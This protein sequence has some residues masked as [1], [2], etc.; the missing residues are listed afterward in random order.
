MIKNP[1]ALFHIMLMLTRWLLDDAWNHIDSIF[2][3]AF[4]RTS[5][6]N[7]KPIHDDNI[8]QRIYLNPRHI[9]HVQEKALNYSFDNNDQKNLDDI[10]LAY[11]TE[12]E[13]IMTQLEK[14]NVLKINNTNNQ[15]KLS[16]SRTYNVDD[17]GNP[18]KCQGKGRP[19]T[20]RLKA[21]NEQKNKVSTTQKS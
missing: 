20:K 3:E 18:L 21:Y 13:T 17:I 11:I 4:I 6:K 12:K 5:S 14:G 9:N 15:L 1:N 2:N 7:L 19:A 16:D 8:D 10:I